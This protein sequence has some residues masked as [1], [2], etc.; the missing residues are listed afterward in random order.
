MYGLS[1]SENMQGRRRPSFYS[2]NVRQNAFTGQ[3]VSASADKL[4]IL[5]TT[6]QAEL[7]EAL[8][9]LTKT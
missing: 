9:G 7:D 8:A 6:T 5:L 1:T 3:Q 2:L 4:L